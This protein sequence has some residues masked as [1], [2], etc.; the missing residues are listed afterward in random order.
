MQSATTIQRSSKRIA[1]Q[2]MIVVTR[3]NVC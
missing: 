3:L 1:C 2:A